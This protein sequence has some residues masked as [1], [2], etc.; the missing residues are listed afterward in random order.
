MKKSEIDKIDRMT[1]KIEAL[2][3]SLN[4]CDNRRVKEALMEAK[5][6]ML[7]ALSACK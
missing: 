2:Q 3:I 5:N 7:R 1:G 4:N 6:A